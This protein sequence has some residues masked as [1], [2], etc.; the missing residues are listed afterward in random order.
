M[1]ALV[2]LLA[3]CKADVNVDIALRDDGSGTVRVRVALDA[4]AVNKLTP[5]AP[6]ERAVPLDDLRQA[7]WHVSAWAK[8]TGGGAALTLSHDFAGQAELERLLSDL[9]PPGTFARTH[10]ERRRGLLRSRD[11]LETDVDLRNVAAG[12]K[13][14][15]T[16]ATNLRAAGVDVDTLDSQLTKQLRDALTVELAVHAPDGTTRRVTVRPGS[17]GRAA[18]STTT[19]EWKRLLAF[20]VAG[21]LFVVALVLLVTARRSKRR[22]TARAR[23]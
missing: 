20:V 10:V 14:D 16:L 6:L 9:A 18:V 1:L 19:F 15:A 22:R 23:R 8:N 21:L 3:A 17:T 7:G 4:E 2:V 13:A 11:E 5:F 12:V